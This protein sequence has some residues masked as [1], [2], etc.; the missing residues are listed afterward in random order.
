[1]RVLPGLILQFICLSATMAGTGIK[2]RFVPTYAGQPIVLEEHYYKLP[3]GDSIMFETFKA[4]ISNVAFYLDD[5]NIFAEQGSYH[6]LNASDEATMSFTVQSP[7]RWQFNYIH[8]DLGVDSA[9]ST[10]GALGGDLDPAKGMFW[11]W[12]SGYINCKIEGRSNLCKTRHNEFQLHLGGYAYPDDCLQR[13]SLQLTIPDSDTDD[14]EIEIPLDKFIAQIDLRK[15]NAI[16]SPGNDAVMMAR[17][18]ASV[19]NVK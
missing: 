15:E 6:L 8:F 12:Q 13:S 17:K 2:L 4:Y 16:M 18:L 1:M 5:K 3:S 11:T 14:I 10:S 9:T 7:G 19:F